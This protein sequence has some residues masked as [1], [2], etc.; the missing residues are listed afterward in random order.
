M[1]I[2]EGSV[3]NPLTALENGANATWFTATEDPQTARKHW[4]AAMKPKGVVR[5]DAGAVA[6][7]GRGKSLLPAGVTAVSGQFL[8]GDP[9]AVEGPDG[10][11]LGLGQ[12][13]GRVQRLGE[14][15]DGAVLLHA[16]LG[17][18]HSEGAFT[19]KLSSTKSSLRF[20]IATLPASPARN[21]I[22]A[23]PDQTQVPS[24]MRRHR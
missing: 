24:K 11:R 6:A 8:R 23:A 16:P 17:P 4:I 3:L 14:V 21:Q 18:R 10:A 15:H 9:V 5:L 13:G 22:R 19:V 20:Q 2:S 7:L 12:V 1:A